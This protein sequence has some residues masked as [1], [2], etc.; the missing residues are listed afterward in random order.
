MLIERGGG[1][2]LWQGITSD[3]KALP[4][5]ALRRTVMPLRSIA[6]GELYRYVSLDPQVFSG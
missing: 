3:K 2:S 5:K 6:A 4:N 1:D